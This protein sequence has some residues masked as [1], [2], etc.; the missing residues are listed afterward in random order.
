MKAIPEG[1][2]DKQSRHDAQSANLLTKTTK[3]QDD[4]V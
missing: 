1:N 4:P 3:K 2:K